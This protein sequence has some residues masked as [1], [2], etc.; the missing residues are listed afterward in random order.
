MTKQI[1]SANINSNDAPPSGAPRATLKRARTATPD[2]LNAPTR[3]A[4]NRVYDPSIART[5]HASGTAKSGTQAAALALHVAERHSQNDKLRKAAWSASI[6]DVAQY[7]AI[8]LSGVREIDGVCGIDNT[9]PEFYS[10]YL[11]RIDGTAECLRDFGDYNAALTY[12]QAI[13][14]RCVVPLHN[15]RMNALKVAVAS[16]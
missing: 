1:T 6:G 3:H 8:E 7:E 12:S 5:A 13:A 10:V 9:R 2:G 16:I 15:L 14:E 4:V 11:R